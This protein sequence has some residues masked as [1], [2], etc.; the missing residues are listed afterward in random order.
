M[1]VNADKSVGMALYVINEAYEPLSAN[2]QHYLPLPEGIAEEDMEKMSEL[3]DWNY[4]HQFQGPSVDSSFVAEVITR[5]STATWIF[6][7]NA[8]PPSLHGK[9]LT[10]LN[11]QIYTL[12]SRTD[13]LTRIEN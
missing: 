10:Q 13:A 12:L 3:A 1:G 9:R 2:I 6:K 7:K 4:H 5:F 11:G 8:A